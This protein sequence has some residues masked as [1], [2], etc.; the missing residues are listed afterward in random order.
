LRDIVASIVIIIGLT[1]S[2]IALWFLGRAFSIL[3]QARIL[4]TRGPYAY[5]RHPLYLSEF[6]AAFGVMLLYQQPW[7]A[8]VYVVGVALQLGRIHFEERVLVWQFPLY[9]AYAR[10]TA[11][12]LP[13][14]Y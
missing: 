1:G 6:V 3:P 11:R 13:S 9:Q 4:V 7:S 14:L 10:R 2:S 5:V 8:L 12:L